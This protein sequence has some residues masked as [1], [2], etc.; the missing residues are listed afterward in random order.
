M[1]E[2]RGI[3]PVVSKLSTPPQLPEPGRPGAGGGGLSLI[4]MVGGRILEADRLYPEGSER[5]QLG[6]CPEGSEKVTDPVL[7]FEKA[8][9]FCPGDLKDFVLRDLSRRQILLL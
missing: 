9:K 6:L 7:K 4:W 3:L 1:A 2:V 8:I 5:K